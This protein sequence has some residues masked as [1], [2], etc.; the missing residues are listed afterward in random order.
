MP[1]TLESRFLLGLVSDDS[2]ASELPCDYEPVLVE[3]EQL[4]LLPVVE[5]ELILSLPQVIYHDEA[6]CPVSRDQL[7]SGAD[8]DVSEQPTESTSIASA[9][10]IEEPRFMTMSVSHAHAIE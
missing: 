5:D 2:L 8:A 7:E 4:N 3:N 1:V 6:D 9:K 10:A